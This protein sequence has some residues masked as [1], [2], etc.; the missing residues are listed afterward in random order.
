MVGR[1]AVSKTGCWKEKLCKKRSCKEE[2]G[3]QEKG[4]KNGS[5]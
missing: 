4:G 3:L 5:C 1:E 2:K